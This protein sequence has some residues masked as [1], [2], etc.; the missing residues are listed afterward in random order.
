MTKL[1]ASQ[2]DL[3]MQCGESANVAGEILIDEPNEAGPVGSAVHEMIA[4]YLRGDDVSR[5]SVAERHGVALDDCD[6]LVNTAIR[7]WE[8]GRGDCP[9]LKTFFPSPS[10]EYHTRVGFDTFTLSGRAD[11]WGDA[12]SWGPDQSVQILDWK[13]G[14][15]DTSNYHQMMAYAALFFDS[16]HDVTLTT[17]YLRLGSI[18][19]RKISI[20][21]IRA[22][23]DQVALHIVN[24][25]GKFSPG[26]HCGYC[27]R[28]ATCEGRRVWMQSAAADLLPLMQGQSLPI[29][30][31]RLP[32]FWQYIGLVEKA[33]K[34]AREMVKDSLRVDGPVDLGDGRAFGMVEEN[35]TPEIDTEKAWP[36]IEA[37]VPEERRAACFKVRKTDTEKVIGELAPARQKGKLKAE[38]NAALDAVGAITRTT[39]QT[40]R[41]Y[42][43]PLNERGRAWEPQLS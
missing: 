22:W 37:Y 32:E 5:E 28:K 27:P 10:V 41:E 2:M 38:F 1:R 8:H 19:V 42:T 16:I 35:G 24:S 9:A 40:P 12:D 11:A 7:L 33:A 26:D 21:Q 23:L 43:I 20:A 18:D 31:E 17:V 36:I 6:W 3:F 4:N 13:T 15:K 30:R 39:K 25:A 14:Y 29:V 34:T